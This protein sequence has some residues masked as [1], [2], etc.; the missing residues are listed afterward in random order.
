LAV[1]EQWV[2]N[3]AQRET[4]DVA[5]RSNMCMIVSSDTVSF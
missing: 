1:G 4:E 2:G 3:D 5:T